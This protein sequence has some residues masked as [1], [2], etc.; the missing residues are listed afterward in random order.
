M[1]RF[2]IHYNLDDGTPRVYFTKTLSAAY[3][4]IANTKNNNAGKNFHITVIKC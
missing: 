1:M 2:K 4:F 3:L